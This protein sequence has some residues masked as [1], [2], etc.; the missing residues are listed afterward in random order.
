MA[1][2][3][4]AK[5]H[6]VAFVA[7][8]A[9]LVLSGVFFSRSELGREAGREPPSGADPPAGVAQRVAGETARLHAQVE[10]AAR[11]F[12][13][14]YFR[15]EVGDIDARV[16]RELRAT[17]TPEFAAA[18]LAVPPRAPAWGGFPPLARAQSFEINLS[19]S[20]AFH[21]FVDIA[22]RRGAAPEHLSFEFEYEDGGW[23][24]SGVTE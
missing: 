22:A 7:V 4:T 17:A 11:R 24:A 18:L 10:L 2:G 9:L 3:R 12:L 13:A 20:T 1:E 6:P 8:S 19:Q 16:R 14:P 23:R 21:A 15:Y 5:P